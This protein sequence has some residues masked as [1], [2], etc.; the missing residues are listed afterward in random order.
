[1]LREAWSSAGGSGRGVDRGEGGGGHEGG[2][3]FRGW[4][5]KWGVVY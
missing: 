3:G 5:T 2:G 1:M 4:G